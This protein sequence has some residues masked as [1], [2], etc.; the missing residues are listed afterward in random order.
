[1]LLNEIMG[2]IQHFTPL[3]HTEQEHL[4]HICSTIFVMPL[5]IPPYHRSLIALRVRLIQFLTL[6]HM[7]TSILNI[8]AFWLL[9]LLTLSPGLF[10]KLFVILCGTTQ[11]QLKFLPLKIIKC[12]SLLLY[13]IT[14]GHLDANRCTRPTIMSMGLLN[15]TKHVWLFS[16]ITKSMERIL[17]KHLLLSRRW[18]C[19]L[20][21]DCCSFPMV[22]TASNG[23]A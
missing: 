1:M 11:W 14:K 15:D 4:P 5:N 8:M 19:P 22:R 3:S 13:L 23:C 21:I 18:N 7:I 10:T 6:F 2:P 17:M 20:F 9:W 16:V 12:G